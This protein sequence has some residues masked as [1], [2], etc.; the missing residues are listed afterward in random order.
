MV[1]DITT[2]IAELEARVARLEAAATLAPTSPAQKQLSLGEFLLSTSPKSDVD[3]ALVIG[4]YLEQFEKT[5]PFTSKELEAAFRRAKEPPPVNTNETVNK[6][7]RKGTI[8]EARE[9]K[10]GLKAWTLTNS[11]EARVVDM[12]SGKKPSNP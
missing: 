9:K 4:Y 11:G 1:E 3:K 5:T 8:M 12:H 7:V 6:N 2:R 10:D